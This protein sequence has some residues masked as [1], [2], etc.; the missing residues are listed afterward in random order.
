MKLHWVR[1]SL[2]RHQ[3]CLHEYTVV[4]LVRATDNV[5]L[6]GQ[7]PPATTGP[8]SFS[9][10]MQ[11]V[12]KSKIYPLTR[13]EISCCTESVSAHM[14]TK[15]LAPYAPSLEKCRLQAWRLRDRNH[16]E[17]SIDYRRVNRSGADVVI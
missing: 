14:L 5:M 16:V 15:R 12:L 7:L 11:Y 10:K 4:V 8:L 3:G 6:S 2:N 13:S 1:P 17:L 9:L